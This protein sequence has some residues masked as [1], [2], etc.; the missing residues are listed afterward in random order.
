MSTRYM[1]EKDISE[2]SL[3]IN[4]YSKFKPY[5]IDI[6]TGIIRNP[7]DKSI[8]EF[9]N[10]YRKY[11]DKINKSK[12][13]RLHFVMENEGG[14]YIFTF[15]FR[16]TNKDRNVHFHR[17]TKILKKAFED[18]NEK[19]RDENDKEEYL[20]EIQGMCEAYDLE[21][22]TYCIERDIERLTE[23]NSGNIIFTSSDNNKY[24]LYSK[25]IKR[26]E[27]TFNM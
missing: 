17:E 15:H 26:I 16:L 7:S 19:L 3:E 9:I 24:I 11:S 8:I 1:Q 4:F 22:G 12:N 23:K 2:K 14:E 27:P 6:S 5:M 20:R 10:V 21:Y 13:F 25:R 18:N